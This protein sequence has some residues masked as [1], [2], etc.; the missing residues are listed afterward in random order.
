MSEMTRD[1]SI[2]I[3]VEMD[4]QK[5]PSNILWSAPGTEIQ[6]AKAMLV[7]LF[8]RENRDTLKID[9]WTKDMQVMEMDRFFFQTL[10]AMSDTYFRA[11]GN[12][13][14]AGA[15]QQFTQFFGEKT[16]II[17]PNSEK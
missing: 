9:L 14:M 13:E 17:K 16:E 6:E 10:R 7:A 2:Q 3:K 15:M 11:T 12:K 1:N 5:M 4:E 8:D